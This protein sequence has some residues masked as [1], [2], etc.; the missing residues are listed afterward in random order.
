MAPIHMK[1]WQQYKLG[2]IGVGSNI[3]QDHSASP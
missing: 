3:A 2:K 1:S